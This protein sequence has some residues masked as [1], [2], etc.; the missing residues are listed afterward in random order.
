M[1]DPSLS[2]PVNLTWKGPTIVEIAA[3]SG[4]GTATVDRVVNNRGNVRAVTRQK[5]M[6]AIGRLG[7][8]TADVTTPKPRIIRFFC[9]SGVSFSRSLQ[10]AV[11]DYCNTRSDVQCPFH[12]VPTSK[13]DT[14][15]FAQLIEQSAENSDGMVIVSRENLTVN[16]VLRT[17][18][19][20]KIPLVCIT[21]DL[22]NSGRTAYIGNDQV[23]AG[24]AA[25]YLMGQ[26]AGDKVGNI[27][28]VYSAPYRGQEERELG[29]RRVLR[30]EFPHLDI[31]DRVNSADESDNSY[32][33]V[34]RHIE[35][36]GP[37]IG[38]YNVAAGNIGIGRALSESGL[39]GKVI[40]IGHELNSN[41]RQLLET[42]VMNFVIGHDVDRE[43]AQSIEYILA[44]LDKRPPPPLSPTKIRI[45]TKFNCL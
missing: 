10:A 44:I 4:V 31:D 37:P 34:M 6:E 2:K 29:F 12:T 1:Q 41:S 15:K 16:R 8:S 20:R 23:S 7:K 26:A 45:I 14:I 21:T 30:A 38:I 40:F 36:H 19:A 42:G 24:A 33:H 39:A 18:A 5:V 17:L 22:P 13:V 32:R 43:V 28:M 3:E 35:E 27:L 25:A 9:D 11:D